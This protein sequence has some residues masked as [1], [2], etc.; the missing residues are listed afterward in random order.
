MKI[1]RRQFLRLAAGAVALPAASRMASAQAYPTRPVRL[2]VPFAAGGPSDIAARLIGQFLLERMGQQIIIENRPGAGSNIGTEAV[3]RAPADGYTLL[4]AGT[5]SA[6][7][8]TLYE[9]LNFNFIRDT[10]PVAGLMHVP[11]VL[12]VHPSIPAKTVSE[13]IAIAKANRGR[14]NM[15]SGGNGSGSHITGELFKLM[16][17]VDLQHLPYRGEAPAITDLL[18]G[19]VQ[20][21]FPTLPTVVE[22]IRANRLRALAATTAVRL[23]ALP[24]IPT[25]GDFVPGYEASAWLG[26]VTPRNTPAEIVGKLNKEINAVLAD[27]KMKARFADLGGTALMGSPADF[28]KLIADEIEKWGKVIR[29]ANIKPE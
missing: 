8:A 13:F 5:S 9:K 6:V 7:N 19:Q 23:E 26:I 21:M 12:T 25:V 1:Q 4:L 11:L 14:L 28:G 15:A 29:A 18:S 20:V 17:G 22:H 27:P 24:D 3:I 16:A 2:M 10:A